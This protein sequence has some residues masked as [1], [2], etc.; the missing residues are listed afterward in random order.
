[1]NVVDE[2]L[3]V[4]GVAEQTRDQRDHDADRA[5]DKQLLRG[6]EVLRRQNVL[7]EMD[8]EEIRGADRATRDADEQRRAEQRRRETERELLQA[9]R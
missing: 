9:R 5:E 1:M 6:I 3:D 4:A 2:E 8:R 7:E